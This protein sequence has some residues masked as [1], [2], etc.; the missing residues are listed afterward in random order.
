[1]KKIYILVLI[2]NLIGMSSK[3]Q[4]WSPVSTGVTGFNVDVNAL[5]LTEKIAE[6]IR[7]FLF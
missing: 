5:G 1:M 2:S 6:V 4:T 7:L 3:S